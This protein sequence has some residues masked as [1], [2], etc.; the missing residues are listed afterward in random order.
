MP[1][2]ATELAGIGEA[3]GQLG[4][5][6]ENLEEF[7]QTMADLSVATNLTSEE[8]AAEFAKFANIVKMP[9]DKFDEL[10]STVV[11]LGNNMATTEADIVSMGMRLAGAGEQVGM[12]EADIM[13]LSAALSS[14]GIE[15]EMGGSAMSKVMINMQLAVETGNESLKSFAHVAGMSADEFAR[16][17]KEML[18][19]L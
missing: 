13:G 14:V 2:A 10:G 3:A 1:M 11:A 6:T 9:Q 18:P 7:I 8:G 4:V 12:N 16:A 5:Q 17:Y 15:A 19:M